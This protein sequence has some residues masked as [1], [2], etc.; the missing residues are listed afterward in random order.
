MRFYKYT[1]IF[2][3]D[4]DDSQAYNIH[5]PAMPEICTFGDSL[6][7]ARFMAQDAIELVILSRLEEGEAIPKDSK[8]DRIPKKSIME[9]VVVTVAHQ[10]TAS[11]AA[12]VQ[13]ALAQT[14]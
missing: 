14:S 13:Q 1:V 9:E 12:H 7:E 11:P 10:V 5:V 4:E 2:T 3:K 8:P 6:E